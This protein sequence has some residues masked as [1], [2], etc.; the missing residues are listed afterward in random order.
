MNSYKLTTKPPTTTLKPGQKIEIK[1]LQ[2]L[3]GSREMAWELSVFAPL[4]EE[5]NSVLSNRPYLQKI[6]HCLPALSS[7]YTQT[8]AH[9]HLKK[10]IKMFKRR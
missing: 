7:I 2:K 1:F 6:Q 10:L 5:L 3:L 9:T 8:H 4:G